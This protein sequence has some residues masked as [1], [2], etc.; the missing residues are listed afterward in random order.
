[1]EHVFFARTLD[2][3]IQTQCLGCPPQEHAGDWCC[4]WRFSLDES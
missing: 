3:R 4:S 2:P 1:V